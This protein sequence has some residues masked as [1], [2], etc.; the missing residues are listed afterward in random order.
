MG[1]TEWILFFAIIIFI[2]GVAWD[3]SGEFV[4][5]PA[6]FTGSI[7]PVFDSDRFD[8]IFFAA[9]EK[10]EDPTPKKLSEARKKGQVAKSTDL[11]SIIILILAAILLMYAGEYGFEKLYFFLYGALSNAD[12]KVTIG[13]LRP[14]L[15]YYGYSYLSVVAIVF[16]TVMVAGTVANLSQ[17]GF[18][19][20]VEP[21]KPNFKKLN[22]LEGFK[23]LFSKKTL[24][25]L[26]KTLFKFLLVGYIVYTFAKKNIP[27]VFSSVGMKAEAVFPLTK[28]LI[29]RL[30]VRIAVVL[31]ILAIV[32]FVYQKYDFKKNLKMTKN[33][34]KEEMKQM[35]GDP[36]IKSR[37]K[38]K[39]RQLAMSRMM[40][41]V[42]QATVILTNPT[43][44][45]VALKY[46]DKKNEAPV[47]VAKGADLIAFK[48]REIAK[49][50]DIPLIENKPLAR[51][52]YKR[53]NVGDEV[54]ADL[55]QAVAEILA[56]VYKMKKK[57]RR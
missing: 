47:V 37:R 41:D 16:A 49:V 53:S 1:H 22:P 28:D 21:L 25:N 17:S 8:S 18:L 15:I 40:A 27:M 4:F 50:N 54:P 20:S 51:M 56:M 12:Y 14:L 38:Q 57:H 32:D 36:K 48:I 13:N 10:T 34:I 29:Y 33:E 31:G 55:Y 2:D 39:Q 24:F 42:P 26:I 9:D 43:H 7:R 23:N 30:V 6:G 44:L 19:F 5:L 46:E 35:E 52:L 3:R 45:S 11:N